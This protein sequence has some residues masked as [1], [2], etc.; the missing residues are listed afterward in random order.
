MH[1]LIATNDAVL[2]SFALSLLKDARVDAVVLDQY[3]S[4]VEGSVGI[5]PRR[6]IVPVAQR[7]AGEEVL[8]DAGLGLELVVHD[9]T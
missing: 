8:R 3:M 4:N 7:L 9:D 5:L 2:I 1:V 6:I